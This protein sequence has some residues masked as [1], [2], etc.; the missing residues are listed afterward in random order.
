MSDHRHR[1]GP[2]RGGERLV[3]RDGRRR[4]AGGSSVGSS[5]LGGGGGGGE[6]WWVFVW[7]RRLPF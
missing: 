1:L 5:G 6:V 2:H 3:P 4:V 7:G